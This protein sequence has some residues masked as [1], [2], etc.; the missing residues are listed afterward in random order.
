MDSATLHSRFQSNDATAAGSRAARERFW[1]RLGLAL[2]CTL[3]IAHAV[4]TYQRPDSHTVYPIFSQAARNWWADAPL[5]DGTGFLY[6]PTFAIALTPFGLLPDWLGGVLWSWSSLALLVFALR[7]F[8]RQ[9]IQR[10][11][12]EFS[13]GLFMSL[14]VAGS[15]HGTW[16]GQSNSLVIALVLLGATAIVNRRWWHAG[17]LLA[18][19]VYVKIWPIV[20]A[21]L[22]SLRHLRKLPVRIAACGF[23]LALLPLGTKPATMVW[24]SYHDWLVFLSSSHSAHRFGGYRDAWVIWE[25]FV[26]P[27]HK[28]YYQVAQVLS[29]LAVLCWAAWFARRGSSAARVVMGTISI[30]VTWQMLFGPGTERLTYGVIAP[31]ATWS[32]MIAYRQRVHRTLATA[33][34]LCLGPLATG[35]VEKLLLPL[36]PVVVATLPIGAVLLA[37]WTV[38]HDLRDE[39][40]AD[41]V[42]ISETNQPRL[43]A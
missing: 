10:C 8:C 17:W 4:K 6:S 27:I 41:A 24:N 1:L 31:A 7:Q 16:S 43:A 21:G 9:V 5:H 34:W 35:E 18:I 28:P 29:G 26:G 22:L 38:L 42:T 39:S 37:V 23:V 32:L 36:T 40:G 15:L 19:P 20:V 2:W 12:P 3:A 25:T 11:W 30:W 14:C 33:A 13:E